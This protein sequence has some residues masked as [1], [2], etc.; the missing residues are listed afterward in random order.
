MKVTHI[1]PALFGPKGVVG[2]AERYVLELARHMA[3]RART[4]LVTFGAEDDEMREGELR[5][6][7]LGGARHVRGQAANPFS[8][9]LL[10]ALRDADVVHCHQQHIVASSVAALACR[11]TGRRVVCTDLG[12]G[13]WDIS[14]YI[15]TDRWFHRHLHISDYS[16][17][18]FGHAS[19]SRATVI[20]GGVDT[21]RFVPPPAPADRDLICLFVGRLLPHKGIDRVIEA[22][23]PGV[24]LVVAGPSPDE[25]YLAD[26]HR[27]AAGHDV[28]FVHDCD[29]RQLVSLYQRARVVVLASVYEDRYGQYSPVPELLGQ[30]LLEAMACGA[31]TICTDV[32][33]L[34]EIV[35]HGETGLVVPPGDAGAM[36][37]ALAWIASRPAEAR[38]MGERGRAR[39]LDAFTWPAVV[40]RCL[41]AYVH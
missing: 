2:G 25:R 21:N 11:L 4:T 30:T 20:L 7:V 36:R 16:R 35:V 6:R 33:S 29:D 28:T 23:P 1:V 27:L 19:S 12:G 14:G 37:E 39:V 13:G 9:R 26:L 18:V 3:P 15:S 22:L 24:P 17:R 41:Q 10:G 32:A 31:A 40:T 5:I 38:A 8:A 34:P